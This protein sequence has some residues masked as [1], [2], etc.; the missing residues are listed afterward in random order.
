MST[1]TGDKQR[2]SLT[3]VYTVLPTPFAEDDS[4]DLPSLERLVDF[5]IA[6]GVD[7]FLVLG[8]LGEAAKLTT[9]EQEE[10]ISTAVATA[11]GRSKVVVGASA[12][13]TKLSVLKAARARDLGADALLIA[14]PL[15]D[16]ATILA[17]FEAIGNAVELP[18]VVHDYPQA[19]GI[20]MTPALLAELCNRVPR[21]GAVKLED[22]PTGPKLQA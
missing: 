19:T 21:I 3:G 2:T 14:P 17:H 11:R 4:L 8:F 13:G 22:P 7:G 18:I 10:V 5:V 1:S 16:D 6:R 15:Q 20:R 9:A 12:G